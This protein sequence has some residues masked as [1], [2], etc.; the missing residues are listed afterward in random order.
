MGSVGAV[1]LAEESIELLPVCDDKAVNAGLQG[2]TIPYEIVVE[3]RF[4][5]D[6]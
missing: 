1:A 5:I 3:Q 6:S 4:Y 2:V